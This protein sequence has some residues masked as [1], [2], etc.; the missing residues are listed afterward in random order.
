MLQRPVDATRVEDTVT[1]RQMLDGRTDQADVLLTRD[2]LAGG[3]ECPRTRVYAE[4]R[5]AGECSFIPNRF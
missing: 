2:T 1:E 4:D 3:V 5:S